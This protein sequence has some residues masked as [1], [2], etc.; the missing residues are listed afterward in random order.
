MLM[1]FPVALGVNFHPLTMFHF[2][3]LTELFIFFVKDLILLLPLIELYLSMLL[4][5]CYLGDIW[6]LLQIRF[7]IFLCYIKGI[8][9]N[10]FLLKF[11]GENVGKSAS[12][13]ILLEEI[14]VSISIC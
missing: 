2:G 3:Y 13:G 14:V 6:L 1:T 7:N 10:L 11:E 5:Q 9:E 4:I 8:G 12:H